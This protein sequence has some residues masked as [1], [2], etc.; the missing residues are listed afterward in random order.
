L[1]RGEDFLVG[2]IARGTEEDQ[3]IG[4]GLTHGG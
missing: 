3:R 1:Q 4:V 2:Q